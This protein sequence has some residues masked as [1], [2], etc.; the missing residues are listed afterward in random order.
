[1]ARRYNYI[2]RADDPAY[3]R[4]Q[5]QKQQPKKKA[6]KRKQR[7]QR[8]D[9]AGS[10]VTVVETGI[11]F[12]SIAAAAAELGIDASNIV[13]VL[14]GK[15]KT[16]GGFHFQRPAADDYDDYNGGAGFDIPEPAPEPSKAE[17]SGRRSTA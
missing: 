3:R 17:I 10:P 14:S 7:R 12:D 16:A 2:F 11:T 5:R 9:R 13:K 8:V 1:M 15:R 6:P 4:K